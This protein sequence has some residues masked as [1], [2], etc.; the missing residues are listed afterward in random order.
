M[1]LTQINLFIKISNFYLMIKLLLILF[2][3]FYYNKYPSLAI[4][5]TLLYLYYQLTL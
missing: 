2:I 5:I 3:I 1:D 4:T